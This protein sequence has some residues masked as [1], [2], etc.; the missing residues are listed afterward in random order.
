MDPVA[1]L[2]VLSEGMNYRGNEDLNIFIA[3]R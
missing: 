3:L 2:S 1:F